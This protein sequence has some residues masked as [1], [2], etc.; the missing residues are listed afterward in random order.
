[1]FLKLHLFPYP[2][3]K[4]CVL[5][6]KK[7]R[8]IKIV[9]LIPTTYVVVEPKKN[10]FHYALLSG[11]LNYTVHMRRYIRFCTHFIVKQWDTGIMEDY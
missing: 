9:L 5:G 1:M 3:I 10:T 4:T 7:N 11:G 6:A 2:S 8:L